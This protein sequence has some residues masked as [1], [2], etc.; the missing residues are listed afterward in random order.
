M[1]P[2]TVTD[3]TRNPAMC[4]VAFPGVSRVPRNMQFRTLLK[5]LAAA[6]GVRTVTRRVT[7]STYFQKVAN[8][9]NFET[10]DYEHF[11]GEAETS[12]HLL[13][14]YIQLMTLRMR[15]I[16]KPLRRILTTVNSTISSNLWN[17]RHD[18]IWKTLLGNILGFF[19][20]NFR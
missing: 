17:S 4:L 9:V 10:Q 13:C 1:A 18:W 16:G 6:K 14:K 5:K 11:S 12:Q 3:L 20:R 2:T 15:I 8:N 19:T 7:R